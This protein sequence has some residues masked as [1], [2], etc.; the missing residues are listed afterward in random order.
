MDIHTLAGVLGA[1]SEDKLIAK[2]TALGDSVKDSLKDH[3]NWNLL[4]EAVY[5]DSIPAARV[6]LQEFQV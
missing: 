2:L 1:L 4:H 6:L 3:C 5:I